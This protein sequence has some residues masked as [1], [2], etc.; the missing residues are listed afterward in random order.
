MN[1]I[2]AVEPR[3]STEWHGTEGLTGSLTRPVLRNNE[4]ACSLPCSSVFSV[5]PTAVSRVNRFRIF[6]KAATPLNSAPGQGLRNRR[7]G[8][9]AALAAAALAAQA[10]DSAPPPPAPGLGGT[11]LQSPTGIEN[12]WPSDGNTSDLQTARNGAILGRVGFEAG[13]VGQA[14]SFD[15]TNGA[16]KAEATFDGVA[17]WTMQAWLFW[18]GMNGANGQA[19]FYHG[20]MARNGYGLFVIGAGWCKAEPDLCGHTG[21]FGVLYGGVRW[22]VTG[23]TLERNTWVHAALVRANTFLVLYLNGVAAWYRQTAHPLPPSV[24]FAISMEQPLTFNGLIDETAL[25]SQG[26]SPAD[27]KLIVDAGSN[28]MCKGPQFTSIIRSARDQV[29]FQTKGPQNRD[30]IVWVSSDLLNWDPVLSLPN[31]SG[32]LTFGAPVNSGAPQRYYRLSP[33]TPES[34][35][36]F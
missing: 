31:P 19:I 1:L 11:C 4:G 28:G 18:R 14:L 5:V 17:D 3:N 34:S 25:F 20:D 33:G 35:S 22:F 27:L 26:L 32:T 23:I 16:V 24:P 29:L 6:L 7:I 30:V 2:P 15:A 21:E 10:A 36:S 12:W 13:K 9:F 8:W